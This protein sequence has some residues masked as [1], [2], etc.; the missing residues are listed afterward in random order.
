M[1]SSGVGSTKYSGGNGGNGGTV[2]NTGGGGGGGAAGLN[3]AGK[4]GGTSNST[5]QGNGGGGGG[6]NGGG[7]VGADASGGASGN[8]GNNSLGSGGGRTGGY[9]GGSGTNVA[10]TSGGGGFGGT[11]FNSAA[12]NVS[13]FINAGAGA[14]GT[15]WDATHG[16]GGGG[17][18][19]ASVYISSVQGNGGNGGLYGG[20]GGGGAAGGTGAQGLIVINYI[21]STGFTVDTN[22]T[23][24]TNLVAY[25]KMNETSGNRSDSKGSSTLTDTNT[26]TFNPGKQGNAAQF[27]AANNEDLIVSD[28]A[29]TS[30]GNIDFSMAAWVYADALS[31][32]RYVASK[33][34]Y[35]LSY[36]GANKF[37]FWINSFSNSVD[38]TS[39]T[40]ATGTWYFIVAWHDSVG[41]TI[42]IQVNNGTVH[43]AATGGV[44]PT[45][46][47]YPLNIGH[48]DGSNPVNGWD[49][50]IDEFGF[51]KKVLTTQERTDLYNSGNG[52]TYNP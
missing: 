31:I 52:S 35:I 47:T 25:W 18:G 10:A 6:G 30:T 44:A 46:T 16:S 17:G 39:V 33:N 27:T 32:N 48:Y 51:W 34:E 43:S 5:S 13:T 9:S 20:G 1:S 22:G 45:D 3:G 42:N 36:G 40:P 41:D 23:L 37:R 26:V 50:R 4:N 19:G 7:S 49:G 21:P 11:P 28:N 8:G 24:A 2:S 14:L 15:E 29:A 38:A 12:V